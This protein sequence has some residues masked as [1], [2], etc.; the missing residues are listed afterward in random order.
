MASRERTPPP[1]KSAPRET[2]QRSAGLRSESV[3][4]PEQRSSAANMEERTRSVPPRQ[5]RLRPATMT[6]L[7]PRF[8]H[9]RS[10]AARRG[11]GWGVGK[12]LYACDLCA[13]CVTDRSVGTF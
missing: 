5:E 1:K 9:V 3:Q 10:V 8:R 11:A 6:E 13:D 2:R 7:Y 12:S 4:R